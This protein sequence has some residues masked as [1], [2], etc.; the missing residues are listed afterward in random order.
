MQTLMQ[1]LM[2]N[3]LKW[4]IS[5]PSFIR[6]WLTAT[7]VADAANNADSDR[8]YLVT[9]GS[10]TY[11]GTTYTAGNLCGA[12]GSEHNRRTTRFSGTSIVTAIQ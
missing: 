11:S 4:L 1:P 6:F 12:L 7:S 5:E 9:E 10:F 2:A 3:S 8:T